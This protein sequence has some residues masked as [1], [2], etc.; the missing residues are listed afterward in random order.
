VISRASPLAVPSAEESEGD[1]NIA[2][3]EQF[4]VVGVS[5]RCAPGGKRKP[6]ASEIAH[7]I[8]AD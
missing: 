3:L 6:E 8:A 1:P 5:P 2:D 4:L 7:V